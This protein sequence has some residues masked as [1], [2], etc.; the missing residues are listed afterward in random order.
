MPAVE[1]GGA[2]GDGSVNNPFNE[3]ATGLREEGLFYSARAFFAKAS[4]SFGHFFAGV[5]LDVFVRL[6][7]EAVPGEL[8]QDVLTRMGIIAGPFMGLSALV[9]LFVYSRYRLDRRRHAEI[10]A[11][12]DARATAA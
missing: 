5:L 9:A 6:P 1:A 4:Y 10:I 3:L 12:I 7:F 8:D 2:G 11:E